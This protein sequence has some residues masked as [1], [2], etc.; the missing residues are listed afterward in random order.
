M[1]QFGFWAP[2]WYYEPTAKFPAPN[3]LP[4]RHL[5]IASEHGDYFTYKVWTLPDDKWENGPEL[6]RDIVTMLQ[7]TD[8]SPRIE[9]TDETLTVSKN[10]CAEK[11]RRE[12]KSKNTEVP[13]TAT[14]SQK[15]I[16]SCEA[17]NNEDTAD[18]N[19]DDKRHTAIRFS[20]PLVTELTE[21][22]EK[23]ENKKKHH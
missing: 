6:V 13:N 3:F 8:T 14:A 4:A 7:Y 16:K 2:V 21:T 9:Y 22:G 20:S 11:S 18:F 15:R 5:G 23:G 19:A 1:F 10:S 17:V 12:I